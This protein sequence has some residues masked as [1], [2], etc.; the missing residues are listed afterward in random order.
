MITL[1]GQVAQ[2]ASLMAAIMAEAKDLPPGVINLF[3]E[4]GP[5]GSAFLV[6]SPDVPTISF[7]G[8]TGT[9][10]AI[11]A[12]G[13]AQLKR[14]GMEL[15]GKTPLLVFDDADIDLAL[16]ALE[17]ALTVFGGLFC[18]T[19]SRLLVQAGIYETPSASAWPSACATSNRGRRPIRPVTWA[20]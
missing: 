2:T 19:G 14:F 15:G 17:K 9:G 16:P 18:M 13:A 8:S 3:F 12:T 1:P 4:D 6:E 10:R 11:S 7:T 20:P 5:E